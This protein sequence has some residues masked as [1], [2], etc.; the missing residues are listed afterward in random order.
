MAITSFTGIYRPFS[1]FWYVDVQYY[2]F[3]YRTVEHAYQAAKTLDFHEQ[4]EIFNVATPN[5]AKSLGRKVQIRPDWNIIRRK[6]ML[7]LL[8][9]KF[10]N[11]HPTLQLLLLN[12]GNQKLVEGNTWHDNYWGECSC[13]ACAADKK[14]NWLGKLLMLIRMEL[15]IEKGIEIAS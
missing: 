10:D 5:E 7:D 4:I 6:V 13:M 12:T 11:A 9:Q 14:H 15:Q 8:R 2:G 3:M 1:N